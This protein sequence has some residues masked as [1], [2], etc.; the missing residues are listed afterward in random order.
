MDLIL[1]DPYNNIIMPEKT[2]RSSVSFTD[3]C[4]RNLRSYNILKITN[5]A[6]EQ[7]EIHKLK[8]KCHENVK[9]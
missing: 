9:W 8:K 4:V 6:N 7:F 2:F 3:P 1:D 5:E